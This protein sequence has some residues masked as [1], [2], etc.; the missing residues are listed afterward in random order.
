MV[1]YTCG[2]NG[3]DPLQTI[4]DWIIVTKEIDGRVISNITIDGDEIADNRHTGLEWQVG[5]I[6]KTSSPNSRLVFGPVTP[7]HNQSS[8][9]CAFAIRQNA[10]GLLHRQ[11]V[12]SNAGTLTVVGKR[13]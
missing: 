8:Y 11:T 13:L 12:T 5:Q 3:A 1:E 4:P 6:N 7:T 10:N 9:Q 2:F